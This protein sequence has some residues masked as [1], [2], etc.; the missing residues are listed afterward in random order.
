MRKIHIGLISIIVLNLFPASLLFSCT[1]LWALDSGL[2]FAKVG[3]IT[4]TFLPN[5]LKFIWAPF[6]DFLKGK[7]NC[8]YLTI[9]LC[10]S[11][12]IIAL[13]LLLS[14]YDPVAHYRSWLVLL[15]IMNFLKSFIWDAIDGYRSQVFSNEEQKL[16]TSVYMTT[17]RGG[18]MGITA[19]SL[20][21]AKWCGW[22]NMIQLE[23][24]VMVFFLLAAYAILPKSP[25]FKKQQS[26][27]IM[28]AFQ[29]ISATMPITLGIVML[30]TYRFGDMWIMSYLS[31]FLTE[32][33][34]LST[35]S[36]GM[37]VQILTPFSI[38]GIWIARRV[39]KNTDNYTL[40]YGTTIA[41]FI[42]LIMLAST[43][44]IKSYAW[45]VCAVLVEEIVSGF[46]FF[47]ASMWIIYNRNPE[48]P[49]YSMAAFS[50]LINIPTVFVGS[51]TTYLVKQHGWYGFFEVPLTTTLASIMI[52]Q[53]YL[54]YRSTN[55]K[56]NTLSTSTT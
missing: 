21:T 35:T 12:M 55:L 45:L 33:A 2:S 7:L 38:V 6:S 18:L 48:Y 5:S 16:A 28:S 19:L 32:S 44:Y 1:S 24:F 22:Q 46:F 47:T 36:A 49:S 53:I 52:L 26:F 31:V 43:V 13:M 8:D 37:I 15:L 10:G 50:S 23:A 14:T 29:G 17:Y 40:M 27:S 51:A 39:A 41:H 4:Y 20:L 34:G 42:T 9:S 11:V 25:E 56:E 30:M 54:K 3:L